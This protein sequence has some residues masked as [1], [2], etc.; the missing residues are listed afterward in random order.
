MNKFIALSILLTVSGYLSGCESSRYT[1]FTAAEDRRLPPM[2]KLTQKRIA[3]GFF[4]TDNGYFLTNYHVIQGSN[5]IYIT[6]G[7][8]KR[9]PAQAVQINPEIDM[10][11]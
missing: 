11:F 6:T 1:E 5:D 10:A 7:D 9:S 2:D 3:T 4:V 8:G